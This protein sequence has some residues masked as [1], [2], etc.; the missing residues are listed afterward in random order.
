MEEQYSRGLGK[1]CIYDALAFLL[2]YIS[3]LVI[4]IILL[5]YS[6]SFFAILGLFVFFEQ[7]DLHL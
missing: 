4:I 7:N 3:G 2:L 6:T 1:L 5:L